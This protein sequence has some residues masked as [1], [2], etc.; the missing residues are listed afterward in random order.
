MLGVRFLAVTLALA[1]GWYALRWQSLGLSVAV[2]A[3]QV[4]GWALLGATLG[5]L[6]GIA[7]YRRS[8]GR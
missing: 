3:L 2:A 6:I 4:S 1:V 5:K 7:R 8:A